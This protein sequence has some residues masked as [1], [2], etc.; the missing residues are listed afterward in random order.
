[1]IDALS[2]LR[3]FIVA[4]SSVTALTGQR[5]YAGRTFPPPEY[6]AGQYAICFNA[7]GG[8]MTYDR[9]LIN[10]S[11]TFKCYGPDEVAAMALSRTLVDA[12]DD[13]SSGAIRHIELEISGYPLQE[14]DTGWP[15]VLTFFRVTFNSLKG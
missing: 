5:V 11:F 1:M 6:V 2:T 8:V 3:T 14:P 9:R 15:F 13:K 12:I 10:D 7:R 4:Q